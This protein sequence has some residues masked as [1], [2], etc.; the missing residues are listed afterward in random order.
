MVEVIQLTITKE[1]GF[2]MPIQ[3]FLLNLRINYLVL[4]L[5]Y[6]TLRIFENI[7]WA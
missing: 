2:Q 1:P 7:T 6:I 3:T 4:K 5:F